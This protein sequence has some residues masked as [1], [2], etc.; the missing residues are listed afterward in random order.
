[1]NGVDSM[2]EIGFT[3]ATALT[4]ISGAV[5]GLL[6]MITGNEYLAT[7]WYASLV[8]VGLAILKRLKRVAKR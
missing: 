7:L 1:M 5:R 4:Q 6:D 2:G 3:V 8:F